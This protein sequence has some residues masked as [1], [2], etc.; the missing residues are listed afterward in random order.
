M[1]APKNV[2]FL[3]V[4][5]PPSNPPPWLPKLNG[6]DDDGLEPATTVVE[7]VATSK[8][9]TSVAASFLPPW[10]PKLNDCD[11]DGLEASAVVEVVATSG[12]DASAAPSSPSP[13]PPAPPAPWLPKLNGCGDDGLGLGVVANL[14]ALSPILRSLCIWFPRIVSFT[15]FSALL[16]SEGIGF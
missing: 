15:F 11:D 8:G 3:V 6:C 14:G 9:D 10:L 16:L 1:R 7:V 13:P 12:G 4:T 5:A 2:L